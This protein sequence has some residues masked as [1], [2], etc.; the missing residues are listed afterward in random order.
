[1]G[2][3]RSHVGNEKNESAA[4][5]DVGEHLLVRGD[6][7]YTRLP[8]DEGNLQNPLGERPF[9]IDLTERAGDPLTD[10]SSTDG[11][12][13]ITTLRYD[14]TPVVI[15][16]M[17]VNVIEH[18]KPKENEGVQ[19]SSVSVQDVKVVVGEGVTTPQIG[20]GV[21]TP[22][23]EGVTT[24]SPWDHL[25][26][27]EVYKVCQIID[28]SVLTA[29]SSSSGPTYKVVGS[30]IV[31]LRLRIN[32]PINGSVNEMLGVPRPRHKYRTTAPIQVKSYQIGGA[33][34]EQIHNLEK[35]MSRP[36]NT[37]RIASLHDSNFVYVPGTYVG[38]TI[39]DGQL[40]EGCGNGVHF[41]FDKLSAI[42]YV[43][44]PPRLL[45]EYKHH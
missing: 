19:K 14:E 41:F 18:T 11:I 9:V 25:P 44:M 15:F 6:A 3:S 45:S 2:N 12:V 38:P 1:M 4:S 20:E 37:L 17:D 28:T 22:R 5:Q 7:R 39:V 31:T 26:H 32:S 16:E 29:A 34:K 35:E 33:T 40:V 24:P 30:A 13:N 21:T 43:G 42:Q 36:N 23:G 27:I 8:S 10:V